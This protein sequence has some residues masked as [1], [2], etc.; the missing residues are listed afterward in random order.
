[1]AGAGAPNLHSL[2]REAGEPEGQPAAE[3]GLIPGPEQVQGGAVSSPFQTLP[4]I[5]G[6]PTL[7]HQLKLIASLIKDNTAL[8]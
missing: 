5:L 7:H 6:R 3:V 2:V 8:L 1:M 4:L